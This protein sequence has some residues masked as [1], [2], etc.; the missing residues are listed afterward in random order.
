[1][2]RNWTSPD[3]QILDLSQRPKQIRGTCAGNDSFQGHSFSQFKIKPY[4]MDV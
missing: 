3:L 4:I 1:M 2:K